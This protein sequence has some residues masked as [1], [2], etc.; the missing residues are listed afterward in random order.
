MPDSAVLTTSR[1]FRRVQNGGKAPVFETTENERMV[2]ES[3]DFSSFPQFWARGP[4]GE[5]GRVG[6]TCS[7]TLVLQA[8]LSL[9]SMGLRNHCTL[10]QF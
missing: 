7:L 2:F 4:V 8:E 3:R 9:D 6:R 1:E 10:S 5:Q